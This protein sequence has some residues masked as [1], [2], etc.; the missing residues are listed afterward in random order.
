LLV[1]KDIF[2]ASRHCSF[3]IGIGK[4]ADRGQGFGTDAIRAML[5]YAFLE[6]NL[7]AVR[8]EVMSYNPGG[9]RAYEKVGFKLDGTL[10][11]CVYRDGVYYDIYAM[12][13]LRR[14]WEALYGY[15]PV[16]YPDQPVE[17]SA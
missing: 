9:M 3:F 4:A 13:I 15:P 10:R 16:S 1:I 17:P 12:S 14:E 6:M 2:W 8:L 11:A 7:H 5:K